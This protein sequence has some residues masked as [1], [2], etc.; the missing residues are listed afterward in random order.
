MTANV[1]K[2][3]APALASTFTS[4]RVA[5]SP[6]SKP[7]VSIPELDLFGTTPQ[8]KQNGTKEPDAFDLDVLR[9]LLAPSAG[10]PQH[11]G[12]LSPSWAPQPPP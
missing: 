11:A 4:H 7:C 9:G 5:S 10:T 8:C 12:L 1:G 3:G 2:D 6:T